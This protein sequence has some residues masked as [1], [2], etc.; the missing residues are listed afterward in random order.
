MS[1]GLRHVFVRMVRYD[2]DVR[3]EAVE[4]TQKYA[5][6][7][8]CLALT[9]HQSCCFEILHTMYNSHRL[10]TGNTILQAAHSVKE[11]Q[12]IIMTVDI[13]HALRYNSLH[14]APIFFVYR[15]RAPISAADSTSPKAFRSSSVLRAW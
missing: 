14:F 12:N 6:A 8:P 3:P 15:H 7:I 1:L 4:D 2:V 13:H 9:I 5:Y 10:Q 11:Y